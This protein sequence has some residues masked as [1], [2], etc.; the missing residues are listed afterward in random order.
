MSLDYHLKIQGE[1]IAAS[2]EAG[3][4]LQMAVQVRLDNLELV[5]KLSCFINNSKRMEQLEHWLELQ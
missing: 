1:L 4:S 3:F 5:K 2:S